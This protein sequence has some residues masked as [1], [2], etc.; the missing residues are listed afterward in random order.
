MSKK[1]KTKTKNLMAFLPAAGL[2]ERLRPITGHIPKPLLPFMGKPLIDMVLER[3]APISPAGIGINIH[4]KPEMF[5]QWASRSPH[6]GQ[7][8]ITFFEERRILGTGGALWNAKDF[9]SEGFCFLVHNADIL[10]D[11][12]LQRLV[13]THVRSGNIATLATHHYPAFANVVIDKDGRV[14]DVENFRPGLSRPAPPDSAKTKRTAYTGIAVYSPEILDYLPPG[15]SH[16]TAAWL[17]AAR[18]GLAVQTLDFTGCRWNDIGTPATYAAGVLETLSLNGE[19]V[20]RAPGADC[21]RI[22]AQGY[23]VLEAGSKVGEGAILRNCIVM[24]GAIISGRERKKHENSIIGP[25]YCLELP[26]AV[27]RTSPARTSPARAGSP[28][29]HSFSPTGARPLFPSPSATSGMDRFDGDAYLIGL[30]GSDRRY[31][32]VRKSSGRAEN[33]NGS[34]VLMEC[35]PGDQDFERHI[36]YTRFFTEIGVPVPCLLAVDGK[37]KR[38]LFEDL[39]DLSLYAWLKLPGEAAEIAEVY[40]KIMEVLSI[41]HTRAYGHLDRCALLAGRRFDYDHLRWES[42]YFLEQFLTGLMGILPPPGLDEEFHLLASLVDSFP[43]AVVHR[44]FQS[45]NIMMEAGQPADQSACHAPG[46]LNPFFPRPRI[47]DYQGARIGP[48]AYDLASIL[49][50]P[51]SPID[52]GLRDEALDY[53]IG[54][55]GKGD[56]AGQPAADQSADARFAANDFKKTIL[57]CR[58]QRHM[59]ALGAYAFL[60]RAKGKRYFLKHIPEGLRLLKEDIAECS[61][62][63]QK[64]PGGIEIDL[65]VLSR[66]VSRLD[67]KG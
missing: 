38:A 26:E 34:L 58:L 37:G 4:Y 47:I 15:V 52:H 63:K 46:G 17:A 24:P 2:G 14:L 59:Q 20:Y 21:G 3:L 44:D 25:D 10:M 7:Q 49:W 5:R 1:Q 54:L 45:Q 9:L 12:D 57:P 48:P 55:M 56:Q 11:V 62:Q 27:M 13:D 42:G 22:E 16:V 61:G 6:A 29:T 23:L 32:R 28:G 36:E 8:K 40:K 50:D 18:A 66:L 33:S 31:Y 35:L 51:Y 67:F 60:S 19:T 64:N 39:G 30:G 65:P 53:Y 43:K 41:L